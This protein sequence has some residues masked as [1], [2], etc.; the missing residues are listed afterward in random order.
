MG[1]NR[2]GFFK[3]CGI[4]FFTPIMGLIQRPLFFMTS[5][6]L[7]V[8]ASVTPLTLVGIILIYTSVSGRNFYFCFSARMV[9]NNFHS[10]FP[11]L[12]DCSLSCRCCS[13]DFSTFTS[14]F[15]SLNEKVARPSVLT[16]STCS[17]VWKFFPSVCP[18]PGAEDC[19]GASIIISLLPPS[20]LGSAAPS[21]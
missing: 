21:K 15:L 14:D 20:Q 12:L 19:P 10:L 16:S 7:C 2:H 13:S 5:V 1:T 6:L 17:L 8:Y 9:D 4:Y 3:V 11:F 18:I